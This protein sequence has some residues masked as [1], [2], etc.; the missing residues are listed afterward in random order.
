MDP[1][2]LSIGA[3]QLPRLSRRRAARP[4]SVGSTPVVIAG[5]L[6]RRRNFSGTR[7]HVR[8]K[9]GFRPISCNAARPLATFLFGE[10]VTIRIFE[11]CARRDSIIDTEKVD[12]WKTPR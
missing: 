9:S 7:A 11:Q 6:S 5:L 1:L 3:V 2:D 4:A 10:A 12:D 8:M